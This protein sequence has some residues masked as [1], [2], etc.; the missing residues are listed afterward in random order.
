MRA[1]ADDRAE[2]AVERYKRLRAER[3]AELLTASLL[4]RSTLDPDAQLQVTIENRGSAGRLTADVWRGETGLR[5]SIAHPRATVSEH[6]SLLG[7]GIL[8]TT[9]SRA[10][11]EPYRSATELDAAGIDR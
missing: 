1:M 5:A 11:R 6:G 9:R 2:S 7:E 3:L 4:V 8:H 10:R